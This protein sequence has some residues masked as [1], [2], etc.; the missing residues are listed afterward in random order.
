MLDGNGKKGYKVHKI[1]TSK[2]FTSHTDIKEQLLESLKEHIPANTFDIGYIEAGRQGVRGKMRWIFSSDDID[3]MYKSYKSASKTEIIL[4]CDGQKQTTGKKRPLAAAEQNEGS[5]KRS[6]TPCSE[7]IRKAM[8]EV[9]TIFQNL[10]EKHH[11]T[12]SPE[13]LKVWAHLISNGSHKSYDTAP[14]KRFF[15]GG[16]GKSTGTS[17]SEL[18]P[19]KRCNLRSQY[20]VQLKDLHM[21]YESGALN[22]EEFDDQKSKIMEQLN[23]L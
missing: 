11:G 12:Y 5:S 14:N 20:V 13:Q 9:T 16:K 15:H 17:A 1:R 21:L 2:R 6:R 7:S 4:W 18:S 10:D 22:K 8:D 23:K 3:D 19:A